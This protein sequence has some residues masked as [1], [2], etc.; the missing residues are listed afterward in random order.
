M[1]SAHQSSRLSQI[2]RV[3]R[4]TSAEYQWQAQLGGRT[5]YFRT[6]IS[7]LRNDEDL[8][9]GAVGVTR[10]V[11]EATALDD[12]YQHTAELLHAVIAGSPVAIFMLDAEGRIR[13]ATPAALG[14]AGSV[15]VVCPARRTTV[16]KDTAAGR[17]L[18]GRSRAANRRRR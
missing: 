15:P 3:L 9:V 12:A 6:T 7:P 11:T 2:W 10:D 16:R 5:L 18:S 14:A 1:S 17:L 13:S 8:V 4:G